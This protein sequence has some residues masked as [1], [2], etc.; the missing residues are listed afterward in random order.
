M[1][2]CGE[3]SHRH[4]HPYE[5]IQQRTFSFILSKSLTRHGQWV[6]IV[7]DTC[8][9]CQS[10]ATN[11]GCIWLK[12]TRFFQHRHAWTYLFTFEIFNYKGFRCHRSLDLRFLQ[13]C[14]Q[15]WLYSIFSDQNHYI[16]PSWCDAIYIPHVIGPRQLTIHCYMRDK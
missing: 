14:F 11:P 13:A 2:S 4:K 1:A 3:W 8:Q 6:R 12:K 10:C 5:Y 15:N 16:S 7:K 9:S